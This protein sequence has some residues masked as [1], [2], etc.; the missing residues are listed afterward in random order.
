MAVFLNQ[1]YPLHLVFKVK[2]SSS[3]I[4]IVNNSYHLNNVRDINTK[5]P[6]LNRFI[7]IPH[8][9]INFGN[10]DFIQINPYGSFYSL[11][12]ANRKMKLLISKF[13]ININDRIFVFNGQELMNNAV[14]T[15][16]FRKY[17]K[18]II[19]VDDGTTGINFYLYKGNHKY[20]GIY[21]YIKIGLFRII[22][23]VKLTMTRLNSNYYYSLHN[24]FVKHIIFPFKVN[25]HGK[26]KVE[27]IFLDKKYKGYNPNSNSAI[28]L[29][30]PLYLD[31]PGYISINNYIILIDKILDK[32]V[33]NLD[34]V[35][36]KPHPNDKLEITESIN[37]ND[38]IRILNSSV[39]VEEYYNNISFGVVYSFNSNGILQLLSS[40]VKTIWLYKL[41]KSQQ[42]DS[43]FYFMED[44]IVL[45]N[46]ELVNDL[47]CL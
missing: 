1:E 36:F 41:L 45:N 12:G 17:C 19:V 43:D 18:N 25:Y 38:K 8:R 3:N 11:F 23:R 35:Y 39:I 14:L 30:Q 2:N 20:I 40:E 46:G 10:N 33:K 4:W 44:L 13:H 34:V 42:L 31:D 29:S 7:Y 15:Y 6:G 5:Y 32:L 21:S 47:N 27:N 37:K 24:V 22:H 16:I 28:F 9:D 26:I